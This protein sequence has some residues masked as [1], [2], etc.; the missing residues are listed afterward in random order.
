MTKLR[1]ETPIPIDEWPLLAGF[2]A[3][4][5][6][7]MFRQDQP[8]EW[9]RGWMAWQSKTDGQK[10]SIG[11]RIQIAKQKRESPATVI[12]RSVS[13]KIRRYVKSAPARSLPSAG[14]TKTE[15]SSPT[16]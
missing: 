9:R 14:P 15:S 6:G 1:K 13:V 2:L 12:A 16:G 11:R 5:K 4:K 3:A 10:I 8:M 7:Q